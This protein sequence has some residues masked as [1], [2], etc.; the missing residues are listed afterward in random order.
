[1]QY[2]P[3]TKT[4]ALTYG[5]FVPAIMSE[6]NYKKAR[7]RGKI[8]VHGLGGNGRSVLIEF[9]TLP[10]KYRE[11]AEVKY[12]DPAEYIASQPIK[13]LLKHDGVAR[14]FFADYKLADGRN[15]PLEYQLKYSRQ[16]E[17]LNVIKLALTDKKV[18]KDTLN[19]TVA[20]FWEAV[21]KLIANDKEYEHKLP[22]SIDR[23]QRRYRV[24]VKEGYVSAVEAWRFGNDYARM[25]TPKIEGLLLALYAQ[26]HKPYMKD[27]CID[28]K[29]FI[30]GDKQVVDL[31]T[32]EQFDPLEFYVDGKP[33]EVGESTVDYYV[34]KPMNEAIVNEGRMSKLAY[35]TLYRPSVSR[36]AAY[37]AF[38][39]IT[40]DDLDIPFKDHEGK[41]PVK[42]Y[43]IFDVASGAVIGVSFSRDKNIELI[44]EALRDMFRLIIRMGWGVPWEIEFEKHLT[45]AMTGGVD[46]DG[47]LYDD[48]LTPGAV[49]PATRMCLGGNAK[50][51]KAE[52]VI[53]V[54][55]YGQQ[56]KRPGF[57]ARH[58][59]KLLTNRL[60]KDQ[61]RV[62]YSY[63]EMVDN[64]LSDIYTHNHELHPKQDLYPN[65]TR[66]Q[67]LE[68]NQNPLLPKYQA[69]TV[70]QFIGY[71]TETSIRAGIARVQYNNYELPDMHLI[72][73]QRYNGKIEAYYLPDENGEIKS[74]YLFEDGRFL[75]EAML[76]E[77]FHEA[78][79]EQ[80][81]H[82]RAIMEHQWGKQKQFDKMIREGKKAIATIGTIDSEK[83][84]QLPAP[85]FVPAAL[86]VGTALNVADNTPA[87]T[88]KNTKKS[89]KNSGLDGGYYPE[90]GGKNDNETAESRALRDV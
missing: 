89:I 25:V 2:I 61:D 4:P 82:D 51:K 46:E 68:Q 78:I 75:C 22:T 28:Y 16:C 37:Y 52:G 66:W 43:Q 55:K 88:S 71:R 13:G 5:E 1:M 19:I 40:M 17:W 12:G 32:G 27:V 79:I 30:R 11:I 35:N 64:E 90:N 33:Y 86:P 47:T 42:S 72:G 39:K 73:N 7:Q 58:Y 69:Q 14:Q 85:A 31:T 63:E 65:M 29:K 38:S 77:R 62:R 67:V 81:E 34:K 84:L 36:I 45:T 15:L 3:N 8:S 57:Q 80:D 26:P 20:Q 21:V 59:A 50:E 10:P 53:R 48:I 70:M 18:L 87:F 9:Y 24:Y 74:V 6:E 83:V 44:R 49:F 56:K 54:K 41:R 60:N 23:L 76:Q